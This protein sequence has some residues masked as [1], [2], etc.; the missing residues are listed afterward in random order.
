MKRVNFKWRN[1]AAIAACLAAATFNKGSAAINKAV[2]GGGSV[3]NDLVP[4]TESGSY[5]PCFPVLNPFSLSTFAGQKIIKCM[6]N[7]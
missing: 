1:V 2:L 3:K 6:F 5:F 7:E 4:T